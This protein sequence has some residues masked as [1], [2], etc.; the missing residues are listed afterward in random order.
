MSTDNFVWNDDLVMKYCNVFKYASEENL[1]KF[2]SFHTS[3]GRGEWEIL[4][5]SN[6][7]WI[8]NKSGGDNLFRADA[9][10][11]I[12]SRRESEFFDTLRGYSIHSVKRLG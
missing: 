6:G 11:D 5:F 9:S 2:K 4:A 7:K 3:K 1:K 8:Y 12:H 10:H